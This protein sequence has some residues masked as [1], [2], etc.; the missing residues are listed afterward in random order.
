MHLK[1]LKAASFLCF[2]SKTDGAM[3]LRRGAWN[4]VRHLCGESVYH[5]CCPVEN[6]R[7]WV[8][9]HHLFQDALFILCSFDLH[10][11]ST[12]PKNTL[13]LHRSPLMILGKV[14][15]Q[16]FVGTRQVYC[17]GSTWAHFKT[18]CWLNV[19]GTTRTSSRSIF[20]A[21]ATRLDQSGQL[22]APSITGSK[23]SDALTD[24]FP[25]LLNEQ[26][27]HVCTE[28]DVL[29]AT[30]ATIIMQFNAD[31]RRKDPRLWGNCVR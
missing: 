1:M 25:A 24:M 5:A 31:D 9:S 21:S 17:R 26:I 4:F 27:D 16:F 18:H 7:K 11:G 6:M 22:R 13:Q 10:I 30:V 19:L 8:K 29:I 14:F 2:M 12:T 15:L 20:V 3:D 23:L 28:N